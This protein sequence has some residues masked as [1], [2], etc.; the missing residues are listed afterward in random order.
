MG[1]AINLVTRKPTKPFES[2]FQLGSDFGR[3]GSRNAWNGYA[4]VG[5]RQELFYL[6]ASVSIQD[7]DHWQLPGDFAGT[8]I[9]PKGAR[10]GTATRDTRVNVKLGLTPNAT[11]EYTLNYTQQ[12]GSKGAPL[13]V[14]QDPPNPPNSYWDW[15]V[16]DIRNLYFLSSTQFG[17]GIPLKPS[18]ITTPLIIY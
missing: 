5:A 14:W 11:D 8:S 1:G 18:R 7:C 15:P 4:S 9:Q 12:D 2:Q 6:H 13:N 3:S 10:G 16:W 17:S